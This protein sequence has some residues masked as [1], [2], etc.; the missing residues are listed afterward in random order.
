MSINEKRLGQQ[1]RTFEKIL[2]EYKF[3]APLARFLTGYY[4][5]NKQMGSNDRRMASR[6]L[7]NY[8]RLGS[9]LEDLSVSLRL[10]VAEFLCTSSSDLVSLLDEKLAL[11]LQEDLDTKIAYL[12]KEYNFTV[13]SI[14]PLIDEV[15]DKINIDGF[16]KSHFQQPNL[17]I[18]IHSGKEK[19]VKTALKEERVSFEEIET[20]TL[21]FQN[22]IQLDRIKSIQGKYEVQDL[23]SQRT[24][25]MFKANPNDSW[26]DTC[27]G[28]GGKSILL[29]QMQPSVS[30]LVSDVRESILRNLD[31]R[32][33]KAGI[34]DFSRK[35]IDLTKDPSAILNNIRFDGIII[36]A[37]CSG[38]GTWG[39]TP[40]VLTSFTE[41]KLKHYSELQKNLLENVI[42]YT[43]PGKP[44]I[45]I[46]CSV[47]KRENEE[48]VE[49]LKSKGFKV[50]E[51]S[52]FE[53]AG[54][55]ADTLFAARLSR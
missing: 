47:Y 10:A 9:S 15:S 44:L 23:S 17:F 16:L 11:Q 24:A 42:N 40:E 35:I 45:Y 50:E 46:T 33:D 32:F 14:F 36:D 55:G 3:E 37:P 29:K 19:I 52:Y 18:R 20:N 6:L 25:S 12:K 2:S 1:L 22:G 7:Y 26:W 54:K 30:L 51:M 28:S 34:K 5:Q 48:Q 8:F 21:C 4:K 53:G 13:S 38:S 49:F 31:E 39:R 43:K 27:A 41:E